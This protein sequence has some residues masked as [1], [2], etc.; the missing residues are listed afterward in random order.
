MSHRLKVFSLLFVLL[1]VTQCLLF[2][3]TSSSIRDKR[4]PYYHDYHHHHH[5]GHYHG[6]YHGGPWYGGW[7]Y[8]TPS[9]YYPSY[10]YG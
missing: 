9:L 10:Y 6:H 2:G 7:G 5:H 8:M 1:T 4:A 3:E